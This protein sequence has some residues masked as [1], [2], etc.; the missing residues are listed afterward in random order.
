MWL[1]A[2]W[3]HMPCLSRQTPLKQ[4]S[5]AA[6]WVRAQPSP[7]DAC[8]NEVLPQIRRKSCILPG[9]PEGT[10]Q[11]VPAQLRLVCWC[12]ERALAGTSSTSDGA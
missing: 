11:A 7:A 3:I 1:A 12:K 8:G 2:R 9:A 6:A 10:G 4:R 5:S